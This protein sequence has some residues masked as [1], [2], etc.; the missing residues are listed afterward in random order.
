MP[1]RK[2]RLELLSPAEIARLTL[3]G[4]IRIPPIENPFR[5][6]RSDAERLWDSLYRGYPMNPLVFWE[7]PAQAE[8]VDIGPLR[9]DVPAV[10]D[11]WWVVDG[12]Q[13]VIA[14]TASLHATGGPVNPAFRI[15]F[16][17]HAGRFVSLGR[18]KPVP[19]H[20]VPVGSLDTAPQ[21]PVYVLRDADERQVMDIF[22][23]L[24]THGNALTRT[25]VL[26]ALHASD[27]QRKPSTIESLAARVRGFGFGAISDDVIALTVQA[28]R[29]E[30]TNPDLD[31]IIASE[32]DHGQVFTLTG[33]V[34]GDV[35]DF[36]RDECEIPHVRVLP[37]PEYLPVLAKFMALSGPPA[38]RVTELL[39]RWAWRVPAAAVSSEDAWESDTIGG[40][41]LRRNLPG[42]G[43]YMDAIDDEPVASVR[44]MLELVSPRDAEWEPALGRTS[45]TL[46]W[47]VWSRLT[48]LA[49][50]AERPRL[51]VDTGEGRAGD[52]I[53]AAELLENAESPLAVLEIPVR[54]ADDATVAL[55]RTDSLDSRLIHPLR[56][57]G[58]LV[59]AIAS[60]DLTEQTLR[61]QCLDAECVSLLQAG[62]AEGVRRFLSHRA[63]L[64]RTV[65]CQNVQRK[66]LFG[67][68]D[69]PEPRSLFD[70]E[71]TADDGE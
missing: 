32:E 52:M 34:L 49:L 9:F 25:E 48:M 51:L 44:R 31:E 53:D 19:G 26:G 62:D 55:W 60:G 29:G 67:F 42:F 59:K 56:P 39:R 45:R 18:R 22:D 54:G 8:T 28:V 27:D 17:E 68:P 35:I 36:L 64:L 66:A 10:P 6:G 50:L 37:Y 1:A 57:K 15:F 38:G 14:L 58:E 69:G 13:R 71:G 4:K 43:R 21:I 40:Y 16:D 20:W 70:D 3:S 24:N 2:P 47:D 65:T 33:Q 23:R 61:S 12:Q 11:A 46:R 63:D 5:W 41:D 7:R 30:S